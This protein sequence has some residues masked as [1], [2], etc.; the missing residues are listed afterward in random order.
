M[1]KAC[2][3]YLPGLYLIFELS[4]LH[5][6]LRSVISSMGK[7]V[8]WLRVGGVTVQLITRTSGI[9][10]AVDEKLVRFRQQVTDVQARS[11]SHHQ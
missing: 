5:N 10:R 3:P 8:L 9:E 7:R 2:T 11:T 1:I 4:P 6:Q